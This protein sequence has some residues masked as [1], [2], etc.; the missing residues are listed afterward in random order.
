M[1]P[2][3]FDRLVARLAPSCVHRQ[4]RITVPKGVATTPL[5]GI[6]VPFHSTVL[7]GGID[8]YRSYLKGKIDA[9]ELAPGQFVNKWIP[10]VIGKPFSLSREYVAEVQRVTGSEPLRLLLAGCA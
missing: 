7:R 10:N 1:L 4:D 8:G 2:D 9:Q 6:D 3:S 5:S